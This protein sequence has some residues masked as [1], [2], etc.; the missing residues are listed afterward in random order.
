MIIQSADVSLSSW[1]ESTHLEH[2]HQSWPRRKNRAIGHQLA[3]A[4]SRKWSLSPLPNFIAQSKSHGQDQL[5]GNWGSAVLVQRDGG[6]GIQSATGGICFTKKSKFT[7]ALPMKFSIM[8]S[9]EARV[10][11]PQNLFHIFWHSGSGLRSPCH[12]LRLV[13]LGFVYGLAISRLPFHSSFIISCNRPS[14]IY[15]VFPVWQALS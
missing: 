12:R 3:K 7:L 4:S 5:L 14:N 11:S 8:A 10:Q 2:G 6:E 13:L 1:I 9:A 15:W